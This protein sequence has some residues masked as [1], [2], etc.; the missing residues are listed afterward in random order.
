MLINIISIISLVVLSFLPLLLWAYLYIYIDDNSF[1]RKRFVAGIFWW[2]LSVFPVLYMD[3]I[4]EL[5]SFKYLNIFY[6]TSKISDF[7]S[8]LELGISLS[9][10]I[11]ILLLFILVFYLKNSY[12]FIKT[13]FIHIFIFLLF[14]FLLSFSFYLFNIISKN[15]D[16]VTSINDNSIY[17]W[18]IVFNSFKLIVFYYLIVWFIEEAS[19]HFNF[20]WTSFLYITS[21]KS[22]VKYSIFIALWFSFIE[23]ILYFYSSYLSLWLSLNLVKIYFLRSIFSVS[24]HVLSSSVVSYYFTKALFIYRKHKIN[25]N[26]LKLF[27]KWLILWIFLHAI[28]DITITYGYSFIIPLYTIFWYFYITSIFYRN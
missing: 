15:I 27:F 26:F 7:T 17:F 21:V 22:A 23:N 2:I 8:S 3:K 5:F 11:F 6:F 14:I 24:V 19:K 25:L 28:F 1:S 9:L 18:D 16:F 4:F 20:L 13:F 10:F 12:N